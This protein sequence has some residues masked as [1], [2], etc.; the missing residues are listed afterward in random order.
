VFFLFGNPIVVWGV[1]FDF[2]FLRI[3]FHRVLIVTC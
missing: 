3:F 2:G 1:I